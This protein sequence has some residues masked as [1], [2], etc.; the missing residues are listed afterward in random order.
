MDDSYGARYMQQPKFAYEGGTKKT[1][2]W[3]CVDYEDKG[4]RTWKNS[5]TRQE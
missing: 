5:E 4:D 2:T 1:G 3:S